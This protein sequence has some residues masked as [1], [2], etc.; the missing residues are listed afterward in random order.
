LLHLAT[1]SHE[2]S[3]D[4]RSRVGN[5]A[6][7]ETVVPGHLVHLFPVVAPASVPAVIK[8]GA[9]GRLVA[10][11]SD[12][13]SPC[14]VSSALERSRPIIR[15]SRKPYI[16]SKE[17]RQYRFFFN[18]VRAFQPN[19]NIENPFVKPR[20]LEPHEKAVILRRTQKHLEFGFY[21]LLLVFCGAEYRHEKTR[22]IADILR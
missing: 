10:K 6:A 9:P 3:N 15:F 7:V 22:P 20:S 5:L 18:A 8:P 1:M 19:S 12:L 17:L 21:R 14:P 4:S 13:T 16:G 11:A 2:R